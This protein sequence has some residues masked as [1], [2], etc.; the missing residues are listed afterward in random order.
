MVKYA[1]FIHITTLAAEFY[2]KS[3]KTKTL[4]SYLFSVSISAIHYVYMP[5]VFIRRTS[6]PLQMKHHKSK[7][8]AK[9]EPLVSRK[10][11][12]FSMLLVDA[13]GAGE[14]DST[15]LPEVLR[16]EGSVQVRVHVSGALL[17]RPRVGDKG[18]S[19]EPF[20]LD[21]RTVFD[22]QVHQRY[23]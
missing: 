13:G 14:A 2:I 1:V 11:F 9:Y 23:A 12:S 7:N 5:R 17:H 8:G 19:F 20:P 3:V 21:L 18:H 15:C 4:E 10:K 16:A 6:R 22:P